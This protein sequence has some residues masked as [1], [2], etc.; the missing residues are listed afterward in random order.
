MPGRLFVAVRLFLRDMKRAW[1]LEE[2]ETAEDKA[3]K[4]KFEETF[5]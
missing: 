3:A 2:P 4:E 1:R 5:G